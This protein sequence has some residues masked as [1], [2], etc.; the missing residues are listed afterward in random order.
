MTELVA[1][2]EIARP[3]AAVWALLADYDND[4]RWRHGVHTMGPDPAGQVRVGTRTAEILRFAGRTYRNSGEVIA[5]DPGHSFRWRTTSGVTATG[6]R[7]VE[8]R[9][10]HRCAVR[11]HV[12]I[13]PAGPDRLV[14]LLFG[15]RLRRNLL[16]DLECFRALAENSA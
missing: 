7:T 15:G 3:A 5:V 10:D 6:T 12:R 16:R 13:T 1:E 2:A 9:G 14:L 11:L 4:P 8:P